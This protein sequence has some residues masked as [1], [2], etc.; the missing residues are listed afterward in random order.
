MIRCWLMAQHVVTKRS[1]DQPSVEVDYSTFI[2]NIDGDKNGVTRTM[3]DVLNLNISVLYISL[4]YSL[5]QTQ[6][7]AS[8]SQGI[9]SLSLLVHYLSQS[10]GVHVTRQNTIYLKQ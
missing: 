4:S 1:S 7:S 5:N 6:T 10:L 9:V 2:K 8:L 3:E